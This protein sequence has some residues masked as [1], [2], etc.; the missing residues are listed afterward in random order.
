MEANCECVEQLSE[1]ISLLINKIDNLIDCKKQHSIN[2]FDIN[3]FEKASKKLLCSVST[4]RKAIDDELLIEDIHYKHNGR[5]KYMFSSS[6]L[7]NVKGKL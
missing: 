5:K 1:V 3:T 6:A 7:L 4:L 2:D